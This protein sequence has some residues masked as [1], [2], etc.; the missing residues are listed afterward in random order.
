M[1][2]KG[3]IEDAV[4][5][6]MANLPMSDDK[7][8]QDLEPNTR[9][10]STQY[11]PHYLPRIWHSRQYGKQEACKGKIFTLLCSVFLISIQYH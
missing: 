9:D 1:M 3:K 7:S 4:D 2:I 5:E 10:I 6:H 11:D 8:E